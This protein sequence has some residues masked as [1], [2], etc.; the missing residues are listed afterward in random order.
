MV[1]SALRDK[2]ADQEA[3]Q[4]ARKHRPEKENQD[5][6]MGTRREFESNG[7]RTKVQ[8]T[9]ELEVG[10]EG[11][12]KTEGAFRNEAR[13]SRAKGVTSNCSA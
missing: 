5:N 9:G 13:H 7:T 6:E 12:S 4:E 8:M 2:I 10:G 1:V 3:K 11:E